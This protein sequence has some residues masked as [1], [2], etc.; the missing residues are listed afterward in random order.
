M[1]THDQNK[2]ETF[3]VTTPIY[4][5]NDRP[6][7][8]HAYSTIAA[9][10]LARYWRKV[11]G[12]ENVKFS[13]GTDENSKKTIEAAKEAD[14]ELHEYTDEMAAVWRGTWDKLGISYDDF[15]RTSEPRHTK[16]AQH[17]VQAIY[18]AGDVTKGA[19]EGPYCFRC[20]AFY[21]DDELV[22][23]EDGKQNCCPVHKKPI[24]VVSEENYFFDLPKYAKQIRELIVSGEFEIQPESRRNEVLSFI[25]QGLEPISISRANQEIG[26]PLPF[27]TGQRTYVW[28]E[29]LIN[30]LTVAGYPEAGYERWWQNVTHIVGKD[31]IKF[32]CIIWPAMLLSAG[33]GLPKR[34]FA[35]G[36][37][38][39]DGEK[40]SKSLGNSIDPVELA[41]KYGTDALRYYLLREIPFGAD[42]N[43]STERFA[44]VYTSDL[45]NGIGNLTRRIAVLIDK[46]YDASYSTGDEKHKAQLTKAESKIASN[47]ERLA[48]DRALAGINGEVQ[49]TNLHLQETQPWELIKSDKQ[50]AQAALNTSA[51]TEVWLSQVLKPFLPSSAEKI[52]HTFHKGNITLDESILFPRVE[53]TD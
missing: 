7:I 12:A 44:D 35:H 10:T 29:A 19:Y 11:L 21:K 14:K 9:D 52:S 47:L 32:H 23:G 27:D 34:V 26:I 24:E 40:I 43:F 28:V 6:H 3:F 45:A 37:F 36:F 49:A 38:T 1:T 51:Q 25:D 17:L 48:F 4:Y 33:V 16:A 8:G 41:D 13:T 39:I 5:I 30:Y 15:I 42:G 53:K 50:A 20:E 46:N 18:D 2:P 31:I 22:A